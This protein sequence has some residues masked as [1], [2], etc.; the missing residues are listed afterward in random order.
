MVQLLQPMRAP[1]FNYNVLAWPDREM[2]A[3]A[4]D[5][6]L[7]VAITDESWQPPQT[8]DAIDQ[9]GELSVEIQAVQRSRRGPQGQL[10]LRDEVQRLL[11]RDIPGAGR[12]YLQDAGLL[13]R[14]SSVWR[15]S[16]AFVIEINRSEME[17]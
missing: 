7:L 9:A 6:S 16:M 13:P 15:Y 17:T 4:M 14:D 11:T 8:Y 3:A 5:R 10:D 1:P 12:C 2:Q